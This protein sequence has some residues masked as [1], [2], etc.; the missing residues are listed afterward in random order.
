MRL[1]WSVAIEGRGDRVARPT[2]K[3]AKVLVQLALQGERLAVGVVRLRNVLVR[4]ESQTT[5]ACNST[6]SEP[7]ISCLQRHDEFESEITPDGRVGL[8]YAVSWS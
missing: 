1:T 2:Y 4:T 5:S 7:K 6:W 3:H 8:D